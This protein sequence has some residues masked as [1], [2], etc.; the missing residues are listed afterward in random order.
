MMS[1]LRSEFANCVWPKFKNNRV[2]AK[3]LQPQGCKISILGKKI[4][5]T[6]FRF[7]QPK[8][9][10]EGKAKSFSYTPGM[11]PGEFKQSGKQPKPP[12]YTRMTSQR[13]QMGKIRSIHVSII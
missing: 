13:G 6:P 11:S 4:H 1:I 10:N 2:Q 8:P 9:N 5:L 3:L 12:F 7:E